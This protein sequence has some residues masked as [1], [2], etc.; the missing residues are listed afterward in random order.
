MNSNSNIGFLIK[1]YSSNLDYKIPR[2]SIILA[3]G[4]GKR[5]KSATSKV[6]YEIWGVPSVIKVSKAAIE[7]I[8]NPN[9]IIVVGIKAEE[10]IKAVGKR[11]N[12]CFVYQ[13]EQKGTGDAVKTALNAIDKKFKGSI[14]IF[15][16]DAGLIT[17]D[18]IQAFKEKFTNSNYDMMVLTGKY[19]GEV[20]KNHYGRVVKNT[21]NREVIEIKE[22]KDIA[23]LKGVYNFVH[24]GRVLSFAKDELLNI[25]EFNSGIYAFKIKPLIKCMSYLKPNN[26]QKEYY[27]TDT[28][29]IFN[30]LNLKVGSKMVDSNY[31]IGFNDRVTL[32]KMENI[33]R[34]RVYNQ[35][36]EI[37]TFQ[38]PE[39]FF[40]AEEV[41]KYILQMDKKGILIDLE[42]GKGVHL[43]QGVILN[44]G[45]KIGKNSYLAGN[46]LLREGVRIGENVQIST[47]PNQIF[48]IGKNTEILRG[49]ILKGNLQIGNDSRIESWVRITGNDEYPVRIGDNVLIKG[50]TYIFGCLIDSGVS[51]EH[52]ILKKKHVIKRLSKN[53]QVKALRYIFP[54]EEGTDCLE[55]L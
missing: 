13:K 55:N 17:K 26:I 18:I 6:L 43:G 38:D 42:I 22:Y 24:K 44:R 51:I 36:K 14:Y 31:V 8:A 11:G 5:I 19:D 37:V 28:V 29:K 21:R 49:D 54:K 15:P 7:G 2:I 16:A 52:C 33:A 3:A 10:V 23:A 32:K 50:T 46:I 30:Q 34:Q 27:L 45:V 9:Q 47:Y 25:E 12:T 4:H 1:K 41:V 20:A 48:K 39:D 40:I 35:L 53:G